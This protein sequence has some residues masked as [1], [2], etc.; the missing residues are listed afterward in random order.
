[1][2]LNFADSQR[3][4][5]CS[6][7]FRFSLNKPLGFHTTACSIHISSN[8]VLFNEVTQLQAKKESFGLYRYAFTYI[9]L[10]TVDRDNCSHTPKLQLPPQATSKNIPI[11]QKLHFSMFCFKF[12]KTEDVSIA[13]QTGFSASW[14]YLLIITCKRII[15]LGS[16][17]SFELILYDDRP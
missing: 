11:W 7:F 12:G 4:K 10:I 1:M 6:R 8:R 2:F 9:L 3:E 5:V 16:L 14:K 13:I 17:L 15:V